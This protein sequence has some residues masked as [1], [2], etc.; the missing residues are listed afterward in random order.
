M[1]TLALKTFGGRKPY[2]F[3]ITT[4]AFVCSYREGSLITDFVVQTTQ[5]NPD[6]MAQANEKLVEAMQPI[7]NVL[8]PVTVFYNSKF[9]KAC[10]LLLFV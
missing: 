7:A 5:V 1:V 2:T 8:D 3:Y 9:K 6:E 4:L 10:I